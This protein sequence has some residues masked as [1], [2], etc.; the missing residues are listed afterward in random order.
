M[1]TKHCMAFYNILLESQI[2]PQRMISIR[3]AKMLFWLQ[4]LSTQQVEVPSI[5]QHQWLLCLAPWGAASNIKIAEFHFS[6]HCW[7][8]SGD[9]CWGGTDYA[10]TQARQAKPANA[11]R[12]VRA[13]NASGADKGKMDP[14]ES[15]LVNNAFIHGA[16]PVSPHHLWAHSITG[17]MCRSL[18]FARIGSVYEA[19]PSKQH[20]WYCGSN[21]GNAINT[22]H[23]NTCLFRQLDQF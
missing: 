7:R 20:S 15:L 4:S 18:Y 9:V 2:L 10:G 22:Y 12:N 14:I 3:C 21:L 17:C 11:R 23:E 1:F 16:S 13:S 5:E 19:S 6:F 8:A